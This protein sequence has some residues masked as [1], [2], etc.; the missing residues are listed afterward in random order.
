[1][2]LFDA[3]KFREK[4]P[5]QKFFST[6][7]TFLKFLFGENRISGKKKFGTNIFGNFYHNFFSLFQIFNSF[8]SI[9]LLIT[10]TMKPPRAWYSSIGENLQLKNKRIRGL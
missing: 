8:F 1:M 7:M 9:V 5:E 2:G 6:F 10:A 4:W 3:Q